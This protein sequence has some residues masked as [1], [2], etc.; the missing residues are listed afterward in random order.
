MLHHT[1]RK[2][3]NGGLPQGPNFF[4]DRR[5]NTSGVKAN[6]DLEILLDAICSRYWGP[7]PPPVLS[8]DWEF[9]Q[10]DE[11]LK[12]CVSILSL[13][14]KFGRYYNLDVALGTPPEERDPKGEWQ[15]L[16][17][18]VAPSWDIKEDPTLE[19]YYSKVH[20]VIVGKIERLCRAISLNF[21]VGGHE[22][23]T[24]RLRQAS[25]HLS[26]F[27]TIRDDDFGRND[28]RRSTKI[29]EKMK[30]LPIVERT[31][32]EVLNSRWPSRVVRKEE[33]GTK[34]PLRVNEA[35]VECQR[36]IAYVLNVG[37]FDF[38]LNGLAR[39]WLNLPYPHRAGVAVIG[40]SVGPLLEIAEELR[41]SG[42]GACRSQAR[43]VAGK[44][45]KTLLKSFVRG[46]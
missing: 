44:G 35:V 30:A 29:L 42:E 1:G 24:G 33:L 11:V 17:R 3:K 43:K 18:K 28:Y 22:D 14:G 39:S 38:A 19:E 45:W 46:R 10:T 2:R 21:T 13:F 15:D 41:A 8:E 7:T 36:E 40:E 20:R 16:E 12:Q 31:K 6:H 32:D 9:L 37:G 26:H 5:N 4:K 23:P 34:W 27:Y 25:I